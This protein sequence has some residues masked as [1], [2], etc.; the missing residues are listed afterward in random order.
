VGPDQTVI[1]QRHRNRK[2]DGKRDERISVAIGWTSQNRGS[3]YLVQRLLANA[4]LARQAPS[5]RPD[6]QT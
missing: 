1:K 5:R 3:A 6:N 2:I 4:E